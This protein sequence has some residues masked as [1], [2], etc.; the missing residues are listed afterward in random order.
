MKKLSV[1]IP[2]FNEENYIEK[3]LRSVRF[4]DEIIVVDSFSSDKTVDIA[5][6]NNCTVVQRQFDNFSNQK[7][8]AL[9]YATGEWVLFID[10]DERIPFT[11]KQEILDVIN[12]PKHAGYKL[13]FPH[14]YMNRFLYHHY[15]SV[16]RLVKRA[17]CKFEGLVH[18]KLIIDG[19]ADTKIEID[20]G[21][22]KD[23]AR[24]LVDAGAD[25]LVAGSAVFKADD[26]KQMI[27][28]LKHA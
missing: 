1:I 18:E 24:R 5:K 12:N 7:N 28:T 8:F 13:N 21:V 10:A 26:A 6:K 9:Q 3:A 2:T 15:D 23:N 4:A 17:N 20:G 11:L 19:K 22:N 16:L 25:V 27:S 14:F